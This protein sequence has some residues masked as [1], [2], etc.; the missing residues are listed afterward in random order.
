ML[1]PPEKNLDDPVESFCFYEV[2]GNIL[3][4]S[5]NDGRSML[6]IDVMY[7]PGIYFHYFESFWLDSESLNTRKSSFD[8]IGIGEHIFNEAVIFLHLFLVDVLLR[9]GGEGVGNSRAVVPFFVFVETGYSATFF[10]TFG[11]GIFSEGY[12]ADLAQLF[13]A[14]NF[15]NDELRRLLLLADGLALLKF[16]LFVV[17]FH[18]QPNIYYMR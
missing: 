3:S 17:V 12:S 1:L 13:L 6:Q 7:F 15:S 5:F 10:E 18:Q 8:F 9:E 2:E 16:A 4:V 11:A 14:C